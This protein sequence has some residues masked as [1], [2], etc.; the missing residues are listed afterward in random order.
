MDFDHFWLLSIEES[1]LSVSL[2]DVGSQSAK[3]LSSGPVLDWDPNQPESFLNAFDQSL[4]QS[5]Q[6][7]T[8]P[9]N[10]EPDKVSLVLPP[11]WLTHDGKIIKD[12]LD[13]ITSTCKKLK[14]KALG[15]IASDDAIVE[16]YNDQEEYPSSYILLGLSHSQFALSLV[17]FGKIKSKILKK[18]DSIFIPQY[19]ETALIE[20][21]STSTLPPQIMVYGDQ[22]ASFISD[23]NNYP[24]VSKKDIE[25]FLHLPNI[26]SIDSSE[27]IRIYSKVIYNQIKSNLLLLPKSSSV[28][29]SETTKS[30]TPLLE[31]Q[32]TSLQEEPEE[33]QTDATEVVNDIKEVPLTDFGFSPATFDVVSQPELIIDEQPVIQPVSDILSPPEL[34]LTSPKPSLLKINFKKILLKLKSLPLPKISL[35][36]KNKK[37][38]LIIASILP[39]F[40]LIPFLFSTAKIIIFIN[41][42]QFELDTQ[43]SLDS[44]ITQ[45]DAQNKSI[46]VTK[47]S[48]TVSSSIVV[49]TTGTKTVGEKAKGEI[50]IY[51]KTDQ[52]VDL[53]QS[54]ILQDSTGQ[55]FE[56]LSAVSVPASSSDLEE[57]VINLGKIQATVVASQIGP[58]SNL[59]KD[60]ELIFKNYSKNQLVAKVSE[61][62]AGGTKEDIPAVAQADKDQIESQLSQSIQQ[63]IDEKVGEDIERLEGLIMD[64]VK[65]SPNRIVYSREIGEEAQE[66]SASVEAEISAFVINP[67]IKTEIIS[68]FLSSNPDFDKAEINPDSFDLTF[69]VIELES[70]LAS[71]QLTLN[72]LAKPKLD[73]TQIKQNISGK[74]LKKAQEYLTNNVPRAI[75]FNIKTNFSFLEFINPLPFR[76]ENITIETKTESL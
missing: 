22:T 13:L 34:D 4:S 16:Y 62:L 27:I 24:W 36:L 53:A 31:V 42:Y 60:T 1:R 6:D 5:A 61:S 15:Y 23:L 76:Q 28:D 64:T 57:G 48:F 37:L 20:L 2:I 72:G 11:F 55:S 56:L 30:T 70:S 29:E 38:P 3:V 49:P 52:S 69:K 54:T 68:S 71:A 26:E 44:T 75:N 19:L 45:I 25:T 17:Y 14:L 59:T 46:P 73:E 8:L 41:P 7:A 18:F 58:E 12:K 65:K 32:T 47:Q 43:V 33:T 9:E 51:N 63:A 35:P 74:S 10:S 66:L 39:I 67:Q 21:N 50:T 40:L